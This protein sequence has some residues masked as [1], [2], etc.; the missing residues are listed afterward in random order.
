MAFKKKKIDADKKASS[1]EKPSKNV[2]GVLTPVFVL[3]AAFGANWFFGGIDAPIPAA[4]TVTAANEADA[5]WSPPPAKHIVEMTPIVVSISPSDRLLKIGLALETTTDVDPDNPE[6][7]DAFTSY[8]RAV[9]PQMLTEPE[10]HMQLKRQLLHRARYTL[11]E[12]VVQGL[13]ITDYL[14]T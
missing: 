1:N 10:F 12:D 7:K 11:G 5:H 3:G 13:L 6:L 2:V 9:T 14:L 8:L 4:Q